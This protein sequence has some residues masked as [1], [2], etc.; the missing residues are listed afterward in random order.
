MKKNGNKKRISIKDKLINSVKGLTFKEYLRNTIDFLKNNILKKAY[1]MLAISLIIATA[2]LT[3]PQVSE[4]ELVNVKFLGDYVEKLKS[5]VVIVVSGIVPYLYAPILGIIFTIFTEC[6]F[7]ANLILE[8]GYI[9]GILTYIL[10]FILNIGAMSIAT[11][12]GVYICRN[13]TLDSKIDNM[14]YTSAIDLR[15]SIYEA[16]NRKDKK[17]KLEMQKKEKIEN[18]KKKRQELDLFQIINITAIVCVM[19]ILAS[20]TKSLVI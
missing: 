20:I 7:M 6:I 3:N 17:N 1:I 11:A 9:Q 18:L 5:I 8:A 12:L 19:Q 4:A 16:A 13:K 15:I 14:K 10:P 2:L